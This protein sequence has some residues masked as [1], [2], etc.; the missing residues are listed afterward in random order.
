[1]PA[2]KF[3][4]R[5]GTVRVVISDASDGVST[6]AD[7]AP[8]FIVVLVVA[9]IVAVAIDGQTMKAVQQVREQRRA[10]TVRKANEDVE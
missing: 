6:L 10:G 1:M 7:A 3:S 5:R 4:A 8:L 9:A 2:E